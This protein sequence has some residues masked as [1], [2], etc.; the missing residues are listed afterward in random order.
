MA[1]D[2]SDRLRA[3]KTGAISLALPFAV[4]VGYP[5]GPMFSPR[6]PSSSSTRLHALSLA[7]LLLTA[8]CSRPPEP[9]ERFASP[10]GAYSVAASA[11]AEGR[12]SLDLTDATGAPLASLP[13]P[14]SPTDSWLLGWMER[15]DVVVLYGR[16]VGACAFKVAGGAL[17]EIVP[18]PDMLARARGLV[19]GE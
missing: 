8:G 18:T 16:S 15:D 9:P 12:L 7:G 19:N 6:P 5:V 3:L 4:A 14:V 11:G 13:T 10:S 17:R 1:V 2:A